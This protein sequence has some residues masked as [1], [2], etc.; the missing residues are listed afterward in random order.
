MTNTPTDVGPT[1]DRTDAGSPTTSQPAA[2]GTLELVTGTV[3]S[4]DPIVASDRSSLGVVR[5]AFEGLTVAEDGAVDDVTMALAESVDVSSDYRTYTFTLRDA[6]FHDGRPVTAEDVV[7]SWERVAAAER[8]RHAALAL[9]T[10]GLF[11]RTTTDADG[12]TT[13]RPDSLGVTAVDDATVRVQ[14]LAP[15][16]AALSLLSHPAFSVVPAGIVGDAG[17]Y[18]GEIPYDAFATGGAVG[19]GPFRIDRWTRGDEVV[20]SRFEDYYGGT[21]TVD[22][23]RWTVTEDSDRQYQLGVDEAVARFSVPDDEYDP[24]LLTVDRTDSHGRRFGTYGPLPGGATV[25]Y[26]SVPSLVTYYTAFDTATVP[27]AVRRAFAH[28]LDQR[29]AVETVF[30]GRAAP[31]YHLTP[32]ALFPEDGYDAHLDR[33]PYGTDAAEVATARTVMEN[34]GYGPND[35][36]ELTV[37][38]FR[39]RGFRDLFQ[40]LEDR[41]GVVHVDLDVKETN[42][43]TLLSLVRRGSVDAYTMGY[44]FESTRPDELLARVYPPNTGAGEDGMFL[45]WSG[46]AAAGRA[47]AEYRTL[48]TNQEPSAAARQARDRA[49]VMTEE[50]TWEDVPVVPLTHAIEERFTHDWAPVPPFGALGSEYQQFD[51]TRISSRNQ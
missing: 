41:L 6:R 32:P 8:S 29:S 42:F 34:A 3:T 7:Y 46:T 40:L 31:A 11:H 43:A 25:E 5:N 4:L 36:F 10:L 28:V 44:G 49:V 37:H 45:N 22:G 39:S 21:P 47:A 50:A 20:L 17:G 9:E 14:L 13:Y 51:T 30:R 33:Y 18:P 24:S 19:A 1:T 16:Y 48:R 27:R 15:N 35:R 26:L 23:V 2:G 38:T 12:E